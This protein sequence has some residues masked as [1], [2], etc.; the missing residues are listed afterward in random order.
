MRVSSDMPDDV[1]VLHDALEKLREYKQSQITNHKSPITL[2]LKGSGTALRFLEVHLEQCYP[3]EP[4]RLTGDARLMERKGKPTS[5]TNSALLMHG[6]DV[7]Y[8]E[9]ESPYITMTRKLLA[10]GQWRTAK[11][12]RDWS[13]AAFWYEYV[14][15]HGGELLLE[16]LTD[17]SIQ[18]DRV[19]ADIY[20]KYFGVQTTLKAYELLKKR[21]GERLTFVKALLDK[22][23]DFTVEESFEWK[24]KDAPWCRDLDEQNELWRKRV[25]ND[26]LS[27]LVTRDY[28]ESNRVDTATNT[29][30]ATAIPAE[31]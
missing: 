26:V 16:G 5:Q 27:R 13:A 25:K 10:N 12:E 11:I 15:I 8:E 6:I 2:H 23:F 22:G 3:G 30:T 7:P 20:E 4:I 14:A 29:V 17:E 21:H 28:A 31:S 24:R 18:G 9:N 1:I 19:V